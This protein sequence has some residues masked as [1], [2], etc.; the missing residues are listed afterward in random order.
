MTDYCLL[1]LLKDFN[2][3]KTMAMKNILL[4]KLCLVLANRP[5]WW[6]DCFEPIPGMWLDLT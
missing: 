6:M 3:R 2:T 1:I 4:I 5:I